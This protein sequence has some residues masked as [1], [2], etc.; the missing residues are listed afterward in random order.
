MTVCVHCPYHTSAHHL[1][2]EYSDSLAIIFGILASFLGM[3]QIAVAVIMC[4]NC[5]AFRGKFHSRDPKC[6]NT[7]I[8]NNGMCSSSRP[9]CRKPPRC[10]DT[11][12]FCSKFFCTTFFCTRYSTSTRTLGVATP[13]KCLEYVAGILCNERKGF[14][15]GGCIFEPGCRG[16]LGIRWT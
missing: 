1:L 15:L 10:P 16:V 11:T 13:Y 9:G 2:A 5:R 7:E 4:C 8:A 3:V 6:C 14:L 12:F